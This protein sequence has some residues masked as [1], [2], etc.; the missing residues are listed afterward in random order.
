MLL[1]MTVLKKALN[2][3]E[4]GALAEVVVS[5]PR[6]RE[7]L[8]APYN[9]GT[10]VTDFDALQHDRHEAQRLIADAIQDVGPY[11][12]PEVREWTAARLAVRDL[13]GG[14]ALGTFKEYFLGKDSIPALSEAQPDD[15]P[16]GSYDAVSVNSRIVRYSSSIENPIEFID[17]ALGVIDRQK[18][19]GI[20]K[21]GPE[22]YATALKYFSDKYNAIERSKDE[23]ESDTLDLPDVSEMKPLVDE[24]LTGLFAIAKRDTP[25]YLEMT[26]VYAA[27]RS[28]PRGVIDQKFVKDI[29]IYTVDNL[30]QYDRSVNN[31]LLAALAKIDTS[32]YQLETAAI[33]NLALHRIP[34]FERTNDL[35]VAVRAID[36]LGKNAQSDAAF[37]RFLELA[38]GFSSPLE[39]EA[40]D[41][42]MERF[43]TILNETVDSPELTAKAQSFA[44]TCMIRA[45]K[46]ARQLLAAGTLTQPQLEQLKQTYFRIKE[47]YQAL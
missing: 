41:E 38:D 14:V 19:S 39:I 22:N 3:K 4:T 47:N 34:Q 28:L 15:L 35:R 31:V 10:E 2:T 16:E 12:A 45:N 11:A 21:I 30:D 27:I 44:E 37:E 20:D 6:Y 7:A 32:Q 25:N 18:K 9:A 5:D 17:T 8:N 42:V 46:S 33:I 36:S 26:N 29:L 23:A 13:L 24:A 43:R 40:V 1:H